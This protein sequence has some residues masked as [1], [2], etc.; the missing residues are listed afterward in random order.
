MRT[1]SLFLFAAVLALAVPVG[2]Q[3]TAPPL[4][5]QVSGPP[6]PVVDLTVDET[7]KRAL[8]RNLDIA[9]ERLNP[10]TFDLSIAGL[11]ANYRPTFTSTT[12]YRD[13]SQFTTS[14]TAGADIL[15]TATFTA[16]TGLA[17]NFKWGGGSATVAFNNNRVENS[18]RF[19]TRNPTLN[20]GLTASLV[21]PLLRGFRTDSGRASLKVTR[22]NQQISETQL[23][24]TITNTLAS[25]RNAYWDL[26]YA[27]QSVQVAQ[28]SFDLA[29]RLVQDNRTRVEVGTMAPIDVVQAEAEAA[30]RRQTLVQAQAT[31]RTAELALKRLIVAGTDDD[32]W[33]A[34]LK[35]VD[36]PSFTTVPVDVDAA[37]RRA[38]AE[39]TDVTQAKQQLEINDANL[40]LLRDQTLPALDLTASYGLSGIGGTQFVRSGLGGDVTQVV[41]SGYW[42]ALRTLRAL[43]A[44][45]WNLSV[46]LSYPIGTSS[47]DAN[48][49]RARVQVRQAQ[50][51]I[52]SLELQIATEVTNIA[53]TLQSNAERV[54]A[55]R[56]AR[57]LAE[58]RL[59]AE[60]SKFEV[61]MS[62]NYFV[63]QAQ[64]DLADA[65][66]TELR[67]LLDYNKSL[68]D[69]DRVQHTSLSR[70]NITLV[71]GGGGGTATT[72]TRTTTGTFGPGGF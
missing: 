28:R 49:A 44:P 35:P 5:P 66:N 8:D 31:R 43:D 48:L 27:D 52:K 22:L 47:S 34:E 62:T 42:R 20:S 55:A 68:V 11:E 21:Q 70:A 53:L 40:T 61:G 64:R 1:P 67:A 45:T 71:S 4:P 51:Q 69:F 13:A 18:N 58:K 24:A 37:V 25:V 30:T 10:Q 19:A 54:Q 14:Q 46:S 57:E 72:T 60:N 16:N 63:V 38:L 7:V 65:Q 17:Q 36:R 50:A 39:R 2:A 12:G 59:E 23:A 29:T 32:V 6:R 9:V 26:V 56:A 3:T 33:R 41:E 15:N